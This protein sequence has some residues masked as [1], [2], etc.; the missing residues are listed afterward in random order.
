MRF[1]K[2]RV[3]HLQSYLGSQMWPLLCRGEATPGALCPVLGSSSKEREGTAGESLMEGY[4]DDYRGLK[5][6]PYEERLR[7]LELFSLEKGSYQ[8]L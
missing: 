3:L 4:R 5:H 7:D 1:N 8:C 6:L 2:C